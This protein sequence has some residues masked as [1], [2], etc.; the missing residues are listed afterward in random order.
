[1]SDPLHCELQ[2]HAGA[3]RDLARD[4]LRDGHAADDVTQAA[5]A[6]AL[7]RSDLQP[8]PLGGWLHRT[9]VNFAKQWRRGERRRA[10]REATLP[11]N[12]AVPAVAE[13][14]ARREMLQR[15]TDA[16]L[17]LDEPYQTAVFLRYFEDLP[18]RAIAKRT[19]SNVAT[20]K[21]RLARGLAMLRQRLDTDRGPRDPRWRQALAIAFGLPLG[22]LLPIPTGALLVST[23][24]KIVAAASVLCVGGL[25]AYQLDDDPPP[26]P[27][28]GRED[29]SHAPASSV[30]TA[31]PAA[32]ADAAE[33]TAPTTDAP[34][35]P[36]LAH[37]FE[38]GI[39]VLV[40]DSLGLPVANHTLRLAPLDCGLNQAEQTTGPDGR[41]ALTWRT[42][43]PTLD[44]QLR[45]P[46]GQVRRVALQHGTRKQLVLLGETGSRSRWVMA[47]GERMARKASIE[48]AHEVRADGLAVTF[49]SM[50]VD[51]LVT[52][53]PG[54]MHAG[55]HPHARFGDAIAMVSPLLD[56]VLLSEKMVTTELAVRDLM[57]AKRNTAS[58]GFKLDA[59]PP[60]PESRVAIEGTVF[61]VDGKPAA[62]VPVALLGSG[63][64]PLQ[65]L[66]ADDEGRFA[67]EGLTAGEFTVRAGG[68]HQGLASQ[69][70]ATTTGVSPCTLQLQRG[71]CVQGRAIDETGKH[72]VEWR[73]LDGS[74]VDATTT[75]ADGTFLLANLPAVPGSVVLIA[76]GD[77][78]RIP[79]ATAPSV[80]PDTGEVVLR[81]ARDGGSVL[82]FEVPESAD[83]AG[84]PSF[85][86][87]HAES[88][89][90]FDVQPPEKGRVWASPKLPSGFYELASSTPG[91][92]HRPLG[93]H[94]L[95]G[96]H[97][98]DLGVVQ[99]ARGGSVRVQLDE[100]EL[101]AAD[102]RVF[103]I[104]SL[105]H[106]LDVRIDA[107][108]EVG[109]PLRLPTGA[110]V[111][112]FRHADGGTRFHRFTVTAG[113]ESVVTPGAGPK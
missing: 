21:S 25:L 4:L 82:R 52:T 23:T 100:A 28:A 39:D 74:H 68:N 35:A 20:V 16:V 46:R 59:T 58:L 64:Q 60:T 45:D 32:P 71:A 79:V 56:H 29:A 95:D 62:K 48:L 53:A 104:T 44:V 92:G 102:Q 98:C 85:R 33:R 91:D 81:A 50:L 6:Q 80:L 103:E 41:V 13:Q 34:L 77:T 87:W 70:V 61:G 108:V 76:N 66:D 110:Y 67:F 73:T 63:P 3:L 101:P 51:N 88:G 106:D 5:F 69:P 12:D 54:T 40:V 26:T 94:W 11:A 96:E 75:H 9:V 72:V 14:I 84:A 1:M 27:L 113:T 65:I 107:V 15:V 78:A 93:R 8:G 47:K 112:A 30:A 18:P 49:R 111:F 86:V 89:V 38:V 2:R 22:A 19:A 43:I 37:P 109:R 42:R 83:R 105:R 36:W 10:A 31:L 90:A 7:A 57:V 17:R 55:L 99:L 24:T 97:E